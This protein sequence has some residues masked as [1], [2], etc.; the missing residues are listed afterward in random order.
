MHFLQKYVGN[1]GQNFITF[2]FEKRVSHKIL[3]TKNL[4]ADFFSRRIQFQKQ[5]ATVAIQISPQNETAKLW[6]KQIR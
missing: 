2:R 3:F 5:Y 1:F 6:P 4:V